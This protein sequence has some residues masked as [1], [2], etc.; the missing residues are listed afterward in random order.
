MAPKGVAS[1]PARVRG[2]ARETGITAV[3]GTAFYTRDAHPDR[4]DEATADELADE[5][6]SDVRDGITTRT[7][8]RGSSVRSGRAVIF[9]SKKRRCCEPAHGRRYRPAFRLVSTH[10]RTVTLSGHRHGAASR[11]SIS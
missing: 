1:D 9:T 10:C 2:I 3:H 7:F 4:I 11:S 6:V 5:F 8:E